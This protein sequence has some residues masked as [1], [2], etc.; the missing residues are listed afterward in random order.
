[1]Q[2][3]CYSIF[4]YIHWPVGIPVGKDMFLSMGGH[5]KLDLM[6]FYPFE[7]CHDKYLVHPSGAYFFTL[8][9]RGTFERDL[10]VK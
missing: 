1:M 6:F 2:G 10:D 5:F 7:E 4:K 9:F 3:E 8:G